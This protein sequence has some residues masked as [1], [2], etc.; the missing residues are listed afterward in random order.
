MSESWNT[1]EALN[2]PYRPDRA[3]NET[4]MREKKRQL[5]GIIIVMA[6]SN[7]SFLAKAH[8]AADYAN[9]AS[10]SSNTDGSDCV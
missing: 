3:N 1:F 7:L 8:V 5:R 6:K 4:T 9:I 2:I 10:K